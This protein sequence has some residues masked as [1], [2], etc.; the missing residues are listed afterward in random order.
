M[1]T[2][3][4][5]AA[6][7]ESYGMGEIFDLSDW[8][9]RVSETKED[10]EAVAESVLADEGFESRN[11]D[12]SDTGLTLPKDKTAAPTSLKNDIKERL[13][14]VVKIYPDSESVLIDG[15]SI[16]DRPL[17]L[18]PG[19]GVPDLLVWDE[20]EPTR[21][22][23]IEVKGGEDAIG[24]NQMRWM[25]VFSNQYEC[26]DCC[27]MWLYT[28]EDWIRAETD[29]WWREHEYGSAAPRAMIE[30]L[31]ADTPGELVD[32]V[33]ELNYGDLRQ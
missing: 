29:R 2:P 5:Y 17:G 19:E 11:L 14:P 15:Q 28:I 13:Q 21:Y 9:F 23:F 16:E 3:G 30:N 1:I 4:R 32:A 6:K 33:L 22:S 18:I 8:G 24:A 31:D 25:A 10:W 7:F 27:F 20:K 12:P 26:F